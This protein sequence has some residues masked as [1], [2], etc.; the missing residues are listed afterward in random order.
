MG[1][2]LLIFG[3]GQGA[4]LPKAGEWMNEVKALFGVMMLGV[5][6]W[7]LSRILPGTTIMVLS[8]LLLIISAICFGALH[9]HW[10][11]NSHRLKHGASVAALLYG[12]I[13]MVGAAQGNDNL[14]APLKSAQMTA[15]VNGIKLV[16]PATLFT[17]IEN[18]SQLRQQ[19]ALAKAQNKPVILEFFASWCPDCRALD[20]N[21]LSKAAVQQQ[22]QSTVALRVD[23]TK[24]T[25]EKKALKQMHK[26]F[27]PPVVIFF[28][29]QGQEQQ[30]VRMHD[31][32]TEEM[33][34]ATLKRIAG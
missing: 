32:I 10:P 16:E 22:M 9:F 7:M 4:W 27:G 12:V 23:F 3:T 25:P 2:P 28:D 21:V 31:H 14:L 8:A 33:F 19:L 17:P 34:L 30:D 18:E 6:I 5:A 11:S 26:V 1:I 15:E 24:E 29:K 13:L 20:A